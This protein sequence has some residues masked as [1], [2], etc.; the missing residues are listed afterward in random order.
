M[1]TLHATIVGG[2]PPEHR[3]T[4][5]QLRV[6]LEH[7]PPD[8]A[9]HRQVRGHDWQDVEYLLAEIGDATR[10]LLTYTVAI[11]SRNPNRVKRPEPLPR[12]VDKAEQARKEAEQKQAQEA[13]QNL[14][15]RL[16][17]DYA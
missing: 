2:P 6:L 7:L 3:V 12:P 13:Y 5:R 1:A 10:Q 8:S 14:V 15:A 9:W 16:T 17:P 11:N 4:L